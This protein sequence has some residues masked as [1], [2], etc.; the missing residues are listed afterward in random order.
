MPVKHLVVLEFKPGTP[1]ADIA[2]IMEG[3]RRLVGVVPGLLAFEGGPYSGPYPGATG[4]NKR[5]THGFVMTFRDA[6]AR[7]A[8]LPHP[9][10][11]R[12]KDE[13]LLPHLQDVIAFDFETGGGA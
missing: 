8:Y 12:F 13:L 1:P 7:A 6:A 10:H 4:L 9:A 2:R 5:Y 11:V 3:L